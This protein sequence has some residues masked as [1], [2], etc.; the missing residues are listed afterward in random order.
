MQSQ[1]LETHNS[2]NPSFEVTV[3]KGHRHT[4]SHI[5]SCL[6]QNVPNMS[7]A[8][9]NEVIDQINRTGKV[10][11]RLGSD[12]QVVRTCIR[13]LSAGGFKV[14]STRSA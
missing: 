12:C 5:V 9:I 6:S 3:F 4:P 2:D 8:E 14:V 11:I 13:G 1:T 7:T 10:T